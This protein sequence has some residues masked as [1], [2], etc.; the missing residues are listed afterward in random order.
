MKHIHAILRSFGITPRY[1]GYK[2]L[3]YAIFLAVTEN[4]RL[5][6]VTR[7]IY[8]EVAERFGCS[9][10]A[11]ERD[12]RTVVSKAWKVNPELLCQMAGYPLSISPTASE[13][14]E[15][16]SSYLIRSRQTVTL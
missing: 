10:S 15:I 1:K 11:V 7:E 9:W 6:S 16:L 2:F 4:E 14:I 12:I 3:A 5:E 13:F 8:M